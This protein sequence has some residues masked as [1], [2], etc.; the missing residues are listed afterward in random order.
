MDPRLQVAISKVCNLRKSSLGVITAM[1]RDDFDND[2]EASRSHRE[3]RKEEVIRKNAA[4]AAGRAERI[5]AAQEAELAPTVDDLNARLQSFEGHKGHQMAYLKEQFKGR[6]SRNYDYPCA[7]IGKTY[8]NK[9]G[10][11][12][13]MTPSAVGKDPLSYLR[14]L[15]TLMVMYDCAV[16]RSLE[17]TDFIAVNVVKIPAPISAAHANPCS[18]SM[19]EALKAKREKEAVPVD[20]PFLIKLEKKYNGAYLFDFEDAFATYRVDK[21]SFVP[22][23][24]DGNP[25]PPAFEATCIEVLKRPDG[26]WAP[27]AE[28][29][30][31]TSTGREIVK[32]KAYV[33]YA[34]AELIDP[35]NPTPR[36][37]VDQYVSKHLELEAAGG[38]YGQP[39]WYTVAKSRHT[40]K[41]L[42][43]KRK[44][45]QAQGK[46]KKCKR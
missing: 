28:D 38:E 9:H 44:A 32:A 37:W 27:K 3:K 20:D 25:N 12:L 26:H 10:T 13:K 11:A 16:G 29:V 42:A 35:E 18:M 34:L 33:G 39:H 7:D 5:N 4:L 2:M 30:V 14:E 6:L 45:R 15:V 21:I 43:A 31:E 17:Q 19:K 40:E 46:Y 41:M 22:N 8:R 23:D 1:C 36:D 24:N